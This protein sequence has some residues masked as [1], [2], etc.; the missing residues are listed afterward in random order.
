MQSWFD[1]SEYLIL[2]QVPDE[3]T[4]LEFA[5]AAHSPDGFLEY[6][7][8]HEP[9]FE[10]HPGGWHTA[11]ALE[12]SPQTQRLCANLPLALREPSAMV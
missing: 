5:D 3:E 1:E 9:D 12:P 6:Y 8:Q 10:G 11:L 7:L 2:L 4:L